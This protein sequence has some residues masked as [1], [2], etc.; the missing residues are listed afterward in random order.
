MGTIRGFER[1][2]T[3]APL[4]IGGA[5]GHRCRTGLSQVASS[6]YLR[7]L[8]ALFALFSTARVLAYLPTIWAVVETSDSSQHSMWTWFIFFG[9]NL[10][11]AVWL[12]EQNGRRCNAAITA[13]GGNALMCVAI[14]AVIAWTRL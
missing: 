2:Q 13:S 11:M 10:T 1:P 5:V 4:A 7:T 6:A 8:G 3:A 9:G 14:I 12:W